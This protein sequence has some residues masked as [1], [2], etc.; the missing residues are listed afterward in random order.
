[1]FFSNRSAFSSR[2]FMLYFCGNIF[3]VLGVW[4]QRLSLGWHAWQL[5]ESAIIVGI[6]AAA[7]YIPLLI[8]TPFF[9]VFADQFKPKKN[10]IVMH[11][12]L[13]F[14]AT[15][16]SILTFIDSM[17]IIY[18]VFLSLLYGI[19]NS[20]YSPVR[21]ALIPAL[22]STNQLSSA[23]AISSA[24]FN[25][26]RFLGP[27][28]A[29]YIVAVY[30]LGY[31]YLVN[32]IT[33][34]PVI[35]ILAFIKVKDLRNQQG[36]GESFFSRLKE[37][38]VYTLNHE[39]IKNVIIIAGISSFFGRGLIELL[40]VF[41][42]TIFEGDSGTLGVLMAS[43]GFGA[44]IA[45]IVYMTG[46]LD[47]KLSKA[48]LYGGYGMGLSCFLFAFTKSLWLGSLMISM[49]GFFITFVAV[50]SQSE[51]QMKV[52]NELRGRVSS[53][54]T[55]I[56]LGGPAIG[57]LIAGILSSLIDPKTTALLYSTMCICLLFYINRKDTKD[58]SVKKY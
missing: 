11:F 22:V 52:A 14:V 29:G 31:A 33:Y 23:V 55:I 20:A 36:I 15:I 46:Y 41:A 58:N 45:S 4:V 34:I 43:S 44:V 56:V 50:G 37:G 5:S 16:L 49:I 48:V 42:A 12:I 18:L 24:G 10:A 51:V 6:V 19:A 2:N 7:Q 21:L 9:G 28:I 39:L 38:L 17:D 57:S 47:M 32:A 25:L 35:I 27:G 40:P 53:L 8:L 13:M 54:W 26:S 3:S 1:M 30:G